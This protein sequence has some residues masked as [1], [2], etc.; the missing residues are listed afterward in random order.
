WNDTRR[1]RPGERP[2]ERLGDRFVAWARERPEATA[3]AWRGGSLSYGALRDRAWRLAG[4]LAALGVGAE[5]PVAVCL[6]RGPDLVA[7]L[8]GVLEAGGA[9]VPLDPEYP[10]ARTAWV[11]EDSGA[12]VVLTQESLRPSLAGGGRTLVE[13]SGAIATG[14]VVAPAGREERSPEALSHVIYTS[15]S[16]GRPKGVAVRHRASAELVSWSASRFPPAVLSSVLASTSVCFDLSVFELFAPLSSGGTVVLVDD[17]LALCSDPAAS[18]ATLVNTVPSALEEVLRLGGLPESVRVVNLAGEALR[19]DLVE[20]AYGAGGV[21]SVLNLY[22]P[23]EDTTYSTGCRVEPGETPGIGRPVPNTRAYVLDRRLGPVPR[24]AVGELG[25]GGANLARGYLGRPS[26]TAESF[27]PDPWGDAGGRLYRTG[28]RVRQGGSGS[29]EFVGRLD[30]QVKVRG[31]RVELGE[32]ESLL[33]EHPAVREAAAVVRGEGSERR[34]VAYVGR[35]GAGGADDPGALGE[36]LR[37]H[38]AA[39]L[40]RHMVPS[41]VEVLDA[42]PRTPNGKLDRSALPRARG[43]AG[44]AAYVAPRTPVEER[45]AAV[46]GGVLGVERVGAHGDFFRLGGHSLLATR[47]VARL[48]EAFGVDL[49]LAALFQAPTP[50]ALAERLAAAA[51][52]PVTPIVPIAGDRGHLPLSFAQER[53]WFL[54]SLGGGTA[55]YN[56][57]SALELSGPLDLAALAR[58]RRALAERHEVLRTRFPEVDGV[59]VQRAEPDR[60]PGLPLIDLG[61][62]PGEAVRREGE[63]LLAREAARPFDLERGPLLRTFV[64]RRGGERHVLFLNSHH[65]ISDEWSLD[66]LLSELGALYRPEPGENRTPPELS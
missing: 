60:A 53:L 66:V 51:G 12:R 31:F 49:P 26:R 65:A 13:V 17:A 32:I 1:A 42:L 9:Y 47:A 62:L 29:L 45:I 10:A 14:P 58:A 24:G 3:L 19:R 15:G 41:S 43:G 50:A 38:L 48:R 39:R 57:P 40:P 55:L 7:A 20:R 36:E 8:L 35:E 16:T 5:E 6:E 25:L 34:I 52:A 4:R 33:A 18:R 54:E 37:G 56:L 59:P 28:D 44:T 30:H 21:E 22:G 2:G 27:V 64:V 61:G 23:S 63:R 11:L 46:F